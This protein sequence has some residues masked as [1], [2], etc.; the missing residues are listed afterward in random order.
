MIAKPMKTLEM[1]YP[2]IEF[3]INRV[4]ARRGFPLKSV[5]CAGIRF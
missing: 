5:N 2:M 3:L 4:I 1:Y